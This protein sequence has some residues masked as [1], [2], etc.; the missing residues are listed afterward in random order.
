MPASNICTRAVFGEVR[1]RSGRHAR[2]WARGEP[3]VAFFGG[4]QHVLVEP[5]LILTIGQ[6]GRGVH[7]GGPGIAR[8]EVRRLLAGEYFAFRF[9]LHSK[10]R[11]KYEYS[12]P[13][14]INSPAPRNL[15]VDTTPAAL[16]FEP[17]RSV[18]SRCGLI[19]SSSSDKYPAVVPSE[20]VTIN[21]SSPSRSTVRIRIVSDMRSTIPIPS[22]CGLSR[23][24]HFDPPPGAWAHK[25]SRVW[26]RAWRAAG[27]L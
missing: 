5:H 13:P 4:P 10:Q 25:R 7:D 14:H 23:F 9:A 12:R 22:I 19:S 6:V 11:T 15:V 16:P 3:L 24:A 21:P 26:V 20:N 17:L 27:S 18:G 2:D 8:A 1:A